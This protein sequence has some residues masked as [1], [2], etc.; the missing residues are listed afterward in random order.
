MSKSVFHDRL[1]NVYVLDVLSLLCVDENFACLPPFKSKFDSLSPC[2]LYFQVVESYGHP[3]KDK[4]NFRPK[5]TSYLAIG[6]YP[7]GKIAKYDG[8]RFC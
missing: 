1:Y 7:V 2:D 5:I 8:V 3:N 6:V 4:S